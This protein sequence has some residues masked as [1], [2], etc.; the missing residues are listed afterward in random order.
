[1]NNTGK[2]VTIAVVAALVLTLGSFLIY[3]LASN[4][5]KEEV[6]T[7][8]PVVADNKDNDK[9]ELKK[10][11]EEEKNEEVKGPTEAQLLGFSEGVKKVEFGYEAGFGYSYEF[12]RDGNLAIIN[13]FDHG[14]TGK[15]TWRNGRAIKNEGED[16]G[17]G[18]EDKTEPEKLYVTFDYREKGSA[19]EIYSTVNSEPPV[20]I[21]TLYYDEDGHIVRVKNEDGEQRFKYDADGRALNQTGEDAYPPLVLF[22]AETPLL[23]RNHKVIRTDS[24]GRP[25]EADSPDGYTHYRIMYY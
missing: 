22:F 23:P 25:L 21:G 8:E 24:E 6:K 17:F 5:K 11:D 3:Q 15:I 9:E 7:E 13:L 1:M 10:D 19:T 16:A 2:Y 14:Y 18:D 4:D 20:K 12:D